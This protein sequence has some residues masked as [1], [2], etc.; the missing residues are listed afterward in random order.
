MRV[1]NMHY[2]CVLRDLM[3]RKNKLQQETHLNASFFRIV[4]NYT[5]WLNMY[6]RIL[7]DSQTLQVTNRFH[8]ILF[9]FHLITG[10]LFHKIL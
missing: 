7:W 2:V 10:F 9:I 6:P 4:F 1:A 3:N 8:S 5:F